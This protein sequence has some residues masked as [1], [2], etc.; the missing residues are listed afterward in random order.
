MAMEGPRE[1]EYAPFYA[2]YVALVPEADILR[3]RYR[4]V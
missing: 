2:R 3:E 4:V 1:D